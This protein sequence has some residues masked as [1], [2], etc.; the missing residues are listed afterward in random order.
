MASW[1]WRAGAED[2]AAPSSTSGGTTSTKHPP[3][4]P[5]PDWFRQATAKATSNTASP[6]FQRCACP[7][8]DERTHTRSYLA[9]GH[10][11]RPCGAPTTQLT[12]G[13]DAP[14]PT[15]SRA[16]RPSVREHEEASFPETGI[17]TRLLTP[18]SP[19]P[20]TNAGLDKSIEGKQMRMNDPTAVWPNAGRNCKTR[21]RVNFLGVVGQI[22]EWME[23]EQLCKMFPPP[24]HFW[25]P[26]SPL[27]HNNPLH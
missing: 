5:G 14:T 15:A 4:A 9:G 22:E 3:D 25:F 21:E 6:P 10:L 8:R 11:E 16:P 19:P 23:W 12:G 17:G 18:P 24:P 26:S 27:H 1:W 13:S 7:A 20:V 2:P